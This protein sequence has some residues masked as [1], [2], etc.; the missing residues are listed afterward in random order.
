MEKTK[1]IKAKPLPTWALGLHYIVLGLVA[2]FS[3]VAFLVTNAHTREAVQA[4]RENYTSEI[5]S[6]LSRSI[7]NLQSAYSNEVKE[8]VTVL[9]NSQPTSLSSLRQMYPDRKDALHFLLSEEGRIKDTQNTICTLSDEAIAS[10]IAN[11]GE[12]ETILTY[13]TVNLEK[14]YLLFGRPM[15]PLS[16]EGTS[17]VGLLVGVSSDEFRA[18]M[19]IS[20]FDGIGAGYLIRED[21]AIIVKPDDASMVFNGYN[22]FAALRDGGASA[23]DV[24]ALQSA[25]QQGQTEAKRTL[26]VDAIEWLIDI[27]KTQFQSEYIVVAVPLSLTAASTYN[28]MTL[29]VLFVVLFI[30]ALAGILV[31]VLLSSFQRRRADDRRAAATEAQSAFLA[32]MSHDIRTPLNAVTGMLQLAS[33]PRHSRQEVDSFIG[34]ASESAEYLL[35]LINGMLDLQKIDSGKMKILH[36]SFALLPLLDGIDSMYRP[37]LSQ[38]GLQFRLDEEGSFAAAY[39]G[40]PT[41]IKQI[42][43]NLLSNAMKFTPEGGSVSLRVS[44]HKIDEK[45]EELNLEVSDTGIGMSPEFLARIGAPFEQEETSV[46][47]HYVG[48]GL[49]LSIVKNLVGLMGGVFKVDSVINKGS[50]FTIR[51]PLDVATAEPAKEKNAP[52]LPFHGER[53]LL[54]EDNAINSQIAV[55]LLKERLNLSV[56]A[57]DNGQKAVTAFAQAAPGYFSAILLDVQMPIMDGLSAAENI[58]A[59]PRPDATKIPIIALSANTYDDDVRRSLAAGMNAHLAKP[60]DLPVLAEALHRYIPTQEDKS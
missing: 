42:L 60:I 28:N 43:M 25:M 9:Q 35:E 33:D 3:L 14:D 32:K 2:A 39:L 5:A 20:L 8:G 6:Q 37:I 46:T 59:L 56:E 4:E 48:T 13:T 15:A 49:G 26:S 16:I 41:K 58:R 29:T 44:A 22:L 1:K 19:T 18:N 30:V 12:D 45:R 7:D 51:L 11:A 38:K 17:Y 36:E 24:S 50:T 34:K 52:L 54:A 21:G 53:V 31:V 55:L 23:S 57:V 10:K 27:H 47:S 40:D